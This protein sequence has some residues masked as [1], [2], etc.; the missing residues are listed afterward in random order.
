MRSKLTVQ[1]GGIS[2]QLLS[3]GTWRAS[4][5]GVRFVHRYFG[6]SQSEVLT[7]AKMFAGRTFR[8]QDPT[9]ETL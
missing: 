7:R 2:L 5:T 3:D 9:R 4:L 8:T 6:I 1:D